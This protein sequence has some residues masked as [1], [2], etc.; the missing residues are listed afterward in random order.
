MKRK[1][2]FSLSSLLL[3]LSLSA[4]QCSSTELTSAKLYIQQK[5]YPKAME[6]LQREIQK[7]PKS[8]EGYYLLGYL[9]G[10]QGNFKEMKDA[11]DKSLEVSNKFEKNIDD[12]KKSHWPVILTEVWHILTGL[13]KFHPKIV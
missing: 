7:N 5:N 13:Q 2:I 4:F 11:L 1:L 6:A 3:L 12:L 10:E 9:Y 8:D